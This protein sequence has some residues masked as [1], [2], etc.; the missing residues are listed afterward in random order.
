MDA[1][2]LDKDIGVLVLQTGKQAGARR[3]LGM[4]TTFLGRGPKCD[5]RLNVDGVDPL[6]CL[7]VCGPGGVQLRD[8]DST[9]GTHVNGTRTEQALLHDGDVLKIGPFQF[10][11]E[12][13]AAAEHADAPSNDEMRD[14]M[15]VQAAAVAAQQAALEEEEMRL[16]QRKSDLQQQEEQLAA[17]LDEKQRQV[18][19]WAD[20]TKDERETLRKEKAEQEKHLAGLEKEIWHA[21]EEAAKQKVEVTQARTRIE[22]IYQRLRQRWQR[23]WAGERAKHQRLAAELAVQRESLQER[24][25]RLHEREAAF[26]QD[27]VRIKGERELDRRSLRE[28][29]ASLKKDQESWRRRR[30]QEHLALKARARDLE[31][32]QL[33]VKQ[34]RDLLAQEKD[35]WDKQQDSLHKELYGLNNRIVH[36]RLRIQEQQEELARLEETVRGR[37]AQ[38]T[39]PLAKE[40][41]A[42][43]D[44]PDAIEID[45]EA[46]VLAEAVEVAPLDEAARRSG[47]LDRLAGELADQRAHLLE[48]Y[49][50]LADIHNAWQRQRDSASTELEAIA[51]RLLAQEQAL[52]ER[53]Q[54][55]GSAEDALQERAHEFEA[56]RQEF[57]NWRNQLQARE[58]AFAQQHQQE[59]MLLRRHQAVLEEQ[60]AGLAVLR[61]R[62]NL[63]RQ[64]EIDRMQAERLILAQEQ[65]ETQDRRLALF[66]KSRQVDEEKRIVAEKALALEQYRQEVFIRAKDPTAQRR[67]ER[68]RRRW[69]SLN[70]TLIRNAKSAGEIT[71]KDMAELEAL[72]EELTNAS[73]RL[74][75][76]E[77]AFAD[78]LTS[79]EE[80]ETTLKIRQRQTASDVEAIAQGIY[81]EPDAP[82]IDQAA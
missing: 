27:L 40:A 50:R 34:C 58:L 13:T 18:Q 73:S 44:V 72:R 63:R 78:K 21:R 28:G 53:E 22:K 32:T 49:K 68:L 4:P 12:L 30:S 6:H 76:E 42:H 7:I 2:N 55:T 51:K 9:Q 46:E 11:L 67:I 16:Q 19:L 3:P 23:Q 69:L 31:A 20:Y 8:L 45:S 39:Q 26:A 10:R 56:V 74:T 54:H 35:A 5:I 52:D 59:T 14:A 61:Q 43:D 48:Q 25:H 33:K 75:Q 38:I 47:D 1:A 29:L 17:H 80:R 62:W 36:Q 71:K 79:L 24:E 37:H 65:K 15:R 57:E 66:E 82:A 60:L 70:S 41:T 77:A 81:Q 64:K